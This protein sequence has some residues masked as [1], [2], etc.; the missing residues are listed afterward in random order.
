M[1]RRNRSTFLRVGT[2]ALLTIVASVTARGAGPVGTAIS[3]QG[4]IKEA[5]APLHGNV[6]LKFELF[7]AK[8]GG[9]PAGPIVQ[10]NDVAVVNGL[11]SVE[12]DFGSEVFNG[13]A[14][15]A[16]ID[17]RNPHDPGDTEPFTPL[18][19]RQPLTAV[20]YALHSLAPWQQNGPDVSYT[21]GNVGIGTTIPREALHLDLPSNMN[22]GILLAKEGTSHGTRLAVRGSNNQIF[23]VDIDPNNVSGFE[24]FEVTYNGG[25][26]VFVIDNRGEVGIGTSAPEVP[27]HIEGGTDASPSDGGYI[28]T[29]DTSGP[30]VVI[31]ENEI[32]ARNNGAV[33][34]LHI[35]NNGGDVIIGGG[36]TFNGLIQP[37][38]GIDLGYELIIRVA[39]DTCCTQAT[40]SPGK[41]VIGGGCETDAGGDAL[42][43]SHPNPEG[44][45]WLC[46]YDNGVF[47]DD[48]VAAYAI[49]IN[50]PEK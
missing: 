45:A 31:D 23:G 49:C 4:Q 34:N 2:P 8:V 46:R 41:R 44:T 22:K 32:M 11:V 35:N 36:A 9:N 39:Q 42:N 3:Y 43:L 26:P 16:Q 1:V 6:D 21:R 7:D 15:W 14:R 29:G 37:N 20:P 28:Q 50:V 10:L 19:P 18:S 33:S 48:E 40:C 5:G 24:Q 25:T 27:L 30:N 13:E 12:V 17:I 38:G 47:G